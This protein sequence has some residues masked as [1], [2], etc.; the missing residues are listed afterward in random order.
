M[1][2]APRKSHWGGNVRQKNWRLVIAGAV[3]ILAA[4]AFFLGMQTI[5][6][7]RFV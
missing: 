1:S 6:F 7:S 5:E 3:M 2:A 4:A